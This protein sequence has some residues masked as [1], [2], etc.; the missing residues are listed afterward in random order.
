M[1]E[2][3]LRRDRRDTQCHFALQGALQQVRALIDFVDDIP[4]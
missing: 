1:L 2:R 4:R 3:R